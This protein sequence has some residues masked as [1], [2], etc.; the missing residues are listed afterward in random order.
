MNSTAKFEDGRFEI[1][2]LW[3]SEN[4]ALPDSYP[5][6]LR[7]LKCLQRKFIKEP[8]LKIQTQKEI[9]NLVQK[10]YAR[11]LSATEILE[12]HARVW[13]LPTFI[14]THPN[15]PNRV[16]LVWDAAAQSWG[17]SLNDF[18]HAGPDLLKPLVDLLISFRAGKV[19]IIG[20][21]AEMF[22]QIRVKPEDAHVQRFLWY[23]Q[24]DELHHPSVYTMEALTF[25]INCAP[26]I[27][28]FIR[29]RNADRFQ[30]QYPAAAQ[31]VK[32]YHY[33]DDF[34]YS[35]NDNKEVIEIATQVRHIHAAGGFY[36]RNWASNSKTVLGKL[37]GK[38]SSTEVEI[39][40]AEKVLGLYWIPETDDLTFIFKFSRLK[41]DIW[42][43]NDAPSK[44]ELLQVLMSMYDPLGLIACYTIE[45]KILLQEVWRT[46]TD[47][48]DCI[49]ESL[50][51]RWNR[52]KQAITL[53]ATVKIPRCFFRTNEDIHDVQLHTFVDASELAYAAVSYLR[54]QQGNSVYLSLLAA[55]TKVAPLSPLSIPRM[56]LQA[57]VTGAKLSQSIQTNSRLSVNSHYY[58]TD[59]KTVLKWLRMDPRKFQQYVMHRVGEVLELN[60]VDQWH[61]VPSDLNPADIATKTSCFTSMHKWFDGPEY[62]LQ[63][64]SRW[65]TYTDLGAPTN[66]EVKQVFFVATTP[67][68]PIVNVEHFSDWRRLYRAVATFI[69]YIEKLKA[70]ARKTPPITSINAEM[71]RRAQTTL[72]RYAQ[73]HHTMHEACINIIYYIPRLRVLYKSARRACQRCRNDNASPK[74]P[75]MA[76][77]PIARV[78][79][80]QRP[81][82]YVGIDYFEPILVTVGRRKEKRWGVIFTCLTVKAVHLELAHSLDASSCIMC[83]RNFFNRRGTPRK[84]F[85]DNGTNFKASEKVICEEL[86]RVDP[87]E[88]YRSFDTIKWSFNPPA[89]PHMGGA[90]ERL[91]GSIKRV[92]SAICPAM[93]FTSESLQSALWEIEFI[94]NSRPLTFVS[95]DTN[96]DE[97]ITPNHLLLGSVSGYKPIFDNNLSVRCIWQSTQLFAD[98][99]WKRWVREYVPDLARR[100]KWYAKQPPLTIGSVVLILDEN[101]PR[102]TWPKGIVTDVVLA[103]DQQVRS[104]TIK[105]AHGILRRPVTKLAVL[106]VGKI[107]G[108]PDAGEPSFPGGECRRRN[109]LQ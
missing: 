98:H 26:C 31:A 43:E 29:D 13:Y 15:K 100:G 57:A 51:P 33:V 61:W 4:A 45:L 24:N 30:Q 70:T 21:I 2:L 1:G 87:D 42:T 88:V 91:I 108:N 20:D 67:L 10:K 52:W 35:G 66:I 14:I 89:A 92:L 44:R 104:A 82:T 93:K 74:P 101:L 18:I 103:K 23:D 62:L 6:A 53:I 106:N 95:L 83:I 38:S 55:K 27:A 54:I 40:T 96:D 79:A 3:K 19:A 76:Q 50:L 71:I 84:I 97:A 65:P 32:N 58:W 63:E 81:F 46:P 69:L 59:S 41:R 34:I 78:A 5:N 75:L 60:N 107:E 80:Y 102:N 105:T 77:L 28:H 109:L 17:Q 90:W 47:W 73:M 85:T 86:P 68:D 48:D 12:E 49:P 36:I 94:I 99:F 56:E 8:A 39:T 7:R 11:K 72:I 37:G 9:D 22:H 25:G 16:R 64:R